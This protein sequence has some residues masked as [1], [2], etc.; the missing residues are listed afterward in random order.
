MPLPGAKLKQTARGA[1]RCRKQAAIIVRELEE[2][3]LLSYAGETDCIG[4]KK[5]SRT[6][7]LR[8]V[9]GALYNSTELGSKNDYG[10]L[11]VSEK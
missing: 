5:R 10:L 7:A 1:A 9:F 3:K 11:N 6:T 8:H 4:C 2:N